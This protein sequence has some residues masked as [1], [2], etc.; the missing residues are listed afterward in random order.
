M[1]D[2]CSLP[3][4]ECKM[5]ANLI[6]S[7]PSTGSCYQL[8]LRANMRQ[9]NGCKEHANGGA[10]LTSVVDAHKNGCKSAGKRGAQLTQYA[11]HFARELF[12]SDFG[13]TRRALHLL[14]LLPYNKG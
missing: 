1:T 9:S 14:G 12:R 2:N 4:P 11:H 3:A 7:W 13:N 5:Y 8:R 10:Q 6:M